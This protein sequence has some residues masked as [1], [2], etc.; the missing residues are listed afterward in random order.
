[1]RLLRRLQLITKR[2]VTAVWSLAAAS[3]LTGCVTARVSEAGEPKSVA[4]CDVIANPMAF[5]DAL[6]EVHGAVLSDIVEYT[7][8]VDPECAQRGIKPEFA[9]RE[10]PEWREFG[11]ALIA[12][13]PGRDPT[14][15]SGIFTGRLRVRS[16]GELDLAITRIRELVVTPRPGAS[17]Q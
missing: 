8:I 6:I 10:S 17:E 14:V 9:S 5:K 7:L 11:E 13:Q 2:S 12:A 4:L 15:M 1:M 3:V 16:R